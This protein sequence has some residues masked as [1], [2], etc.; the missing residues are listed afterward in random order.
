[1]P[2]HVELKVGFSKEELEG[3]QR[4]FQKT[5]LANQPN[6]TEPSQKRWVI[7]RLNGG[8]VE[9]TT[10]KEYFQFQGRHY[11]KQIF[12]QLEEG[13]NVFEHVGSVFWYH[14]HRKTTSLTFDEDQDIPSSP[15]DEDI[16]RRRLSDWQAFHERISRG[17]Y[18][19]RPSQKDFFKFLKEAY[20][21][22]FPDRT[23]DGSVPRSDRD[24]LADPWFILSHHQ[25]QYEISEL[26]AGERVIFPILLDFAHLNINNSVILIDE[27]E[28]HLHPPLQ[29]ALLRA[30]IKLGKN[31]QII[32][33]THSQAIVDIVPQ[34]A[35]IRV[36]S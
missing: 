1:M 32:I 25:K 33:T 26:S 27:L 3:T 29:Q 9:G 11:A 36:E 12:K 21:K 14:E 16:L 2:S 8:N 6:G 31:N 15:I 19:L 23:L 22:I 13:F 18:K 17:E 5:S 34:N 4:C 28:L 24:F 10:A 35:I 30:L 20:A 7:L